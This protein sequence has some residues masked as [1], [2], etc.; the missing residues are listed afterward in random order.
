MPGAVVTITIQPFTAPFVSTGSPPVVLQPYDI[1]DTFDPANRIAVTRPSG[2]GSAQGG[3]GSY[4]PGSITV[5]GSG[6][7]DVTF[8]VVDN[9]SPPGIY[10]VCGLLFS[11]TMS[12]VGL[13]PQT[14]RDVFTHFK[15][16]E[17]GDLTVED[18][19]TAS[20]T[21][22]FLLLI[23]NLIGGMGIIDPQITNQ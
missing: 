10:V 19:K 6:N 18:A 22:N 3:G 21:Y 17:V 13:P 23:Q 16:D 1:A 14:G 15:C 20:A 5:S 11:K 7:L 4:V 9:A 8:H 2:S 12:P